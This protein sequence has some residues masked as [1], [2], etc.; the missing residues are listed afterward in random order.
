MTDADIADIDTP[1]AEL[2]SDAD[3]QPGELTEAQLE[4]LLFVAERPL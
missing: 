1:P 2:A 3:A 4:A